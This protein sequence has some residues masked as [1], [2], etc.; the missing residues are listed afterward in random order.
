MFYY[1]LIGLDCLMVTHFFVQENQNIKWLKHQQMWS[2]HGID[3]EWT[4]ETSILDIIGQYKQAYRLA[5][6]KTI[7][8]VFQP[9]QAFN[10]VQFV[11]FFDNPSS[12]TVHSAIRSLPGIQIERFQG[13][14][15][16]IL[17]LVQVMSRFYLLVNNMI[18]FYFRT[19][20]QMIRVHNFMNTEFSQFNKFKNI[21]HRS[22]LLS[23]LSML[24]FVMACIIILLCEFEGKINSL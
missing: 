16:S 8:L 23:T 17:T 10:I 19:N 6:L 13:F 2:I 9:M 15:N 4:E 12:M 5:I 11:P 21:Y 1:F 22:P 14:V 7:I 20:V 3:L 24:L 18:F